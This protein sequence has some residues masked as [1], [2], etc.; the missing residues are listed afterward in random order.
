MVKNKYLNN[1]SLINVILMRRTLATLLL[2]P[3]LLQIP[4]SA[5]YDSHYTRLGQNRTSYLSSPQVSDPIATPESPSG[6]VKLVQEIGRFVNYL[7]EKNSI[8]SAKNGKIS[9]QKLQKS[10]KLEDSMMFQDRAFSALVTLDTSIIDLDW[11][12]LHPNL[13]NI[14][15][16]INLYADGVSMTYTKDSGVINLC[17]DRNLVNIDLTSDPYF[18]LND[19]PQLKSAAQDLA[20]NALKLIRTK[21]E[22]N[23]KTDAL[24]ALL[25]YCKAAKE[26][27]IL[28]TFPT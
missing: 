26:K 24:N 16:T 13:G 1:S 20:Y 21:K 11:T 27:I 3:T 9:L 6:E 5:H 14:V 8:Y 22:T 12:N 10:N 4:V 19:N 28:S 15:S 23:N 18:E 17:I 2:V 25:G 7:L